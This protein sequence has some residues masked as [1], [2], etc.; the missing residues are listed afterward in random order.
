MVLACTLYAKTIEIPGVND[1]SIQDGLDSALTRDVVQ[2][3]AGTYYENLIWPDVSGISLVGNDSSNTVIDGGGNG[4]VITMNPSTATIDE[5]TVI[6]NFTIQNG[7]KSGNGAGIYLSNCSTLIENVVIKNN[8]S[9]Y[10]G[11][12]IYCTNNSSPELSKL[13]IFN[14]ESEDGAALYSN[15]STITINDAKIY[16]NYAYLYGG[17]ISA[18]ESD[19][20][21]NNSN[22][23]LNRSDLKGGGIFLYNSTL[24]LSDSKITKNIAKDDDSNEES[25]GGGIHS[26]FSTINIANVEINENSAGLYGGGISF[27]SSKF[28]NIENVLFAKNSSYKGGAIYSDNTKF[29][30][31]NS[32]LDN[33]TAS[34]TGDCIYIFGNNTSK[35]KNC[36][37]TGHKNSIELQTA[38]LDASNNYF[39]TIDGPFHENQNVSGI[40]DTVDVN[41]DILPF[42]KSPNLSAPPIAP[43][44]FSIIDESND[45]VTV[46]WDES[47]M[48][49]FEQY[50][51]FYSNEP[52][53]YQSS[54]DSVVYEL[55]G[56]TEFTLN[57]VTIGEAYY[58]A[59]ITIDRNSNRSWY[60]YEDSITIFDK[61][62]YVLDSL[63]D[64]SV[65]EDT[66]SLMIDLATVFSDSDDVDTDIYKS[67]VNISDSTLLSAKI[68]NNTLTLYLIKDQN[69]TAE[70]IINGFVNTKSANDTF[71]V[72]VLPVPD[73]PIGI[74]TLVVINEDEMLIFDESLMRFNDPDGDLFGGIIFTSLPEKGSLD[75]N[76]DSVRIN[77][78]YSE[79][80]DLFYQPEL[81]QYGEDYSSFSYYLFDD[82]DSTSS[83]AYT[84]TINV[85]PVDDPLNVAN[86][87]FDFS[88]DE[89]APD[90]TI[91]L[92]SLFF[93]DDGF[94]IMK[95][96]AEISD[97]TLIETIID[98]DSLTLKFLE[99]QNGFVDI[100]IAG[101][102]NDTSAID[103]FRVIINPINDNP[104]SRD[105]TIELDEDSVFDFVKND[106]YYEDFENDKSAG[107]IITTKP[108]KGILKYL[109]DEVITGTTYKYIQ[110]LQFI[111]DEDGTGNPYTSFDFKMVAIDK[112]ISDSAYTCTII[113]NG[114]D[115]PP[116]IK[117][118][119]QDFVISE[120]FPDTLI[121]LAEIFTD[122]DDSI[123]VKS[124]VSIS[125]TLL[126]IGEIFGDSLVLTFG[127][128]QFGSSE[129]VIEA[130]ANSKSVTDTML[131]TILPVNDKPFSKNDTIN[132]LEDE[133]YQFS[134]EDFYYKDIEN[135]SFTEI[136]IVR[137]VESGIFKL[138]NAEVDSIIP[139]VDI[140]YLTF[141]PA[142]NQIGSP[143][144]FFTFQVKDEDEFSDSLYT[145]II[146]VIGKNDP[147]SFVGTYPDTI[148][149]EDQLLSLDIIATDPE[150]DSLIFAI[151]SFFV[152]NESSWEFVEPANFDIFLDSNHFQWQPTFEHSNEY[153][154]KISVSD[155][156]YRDTTAFVITV[157]NINR[158]PT[159]TKF[160]TDTTINNDLEF[161][162][163]FSANDPDNDSLYYG[164]IENIDG[165]S[166]SDSGF[167]HWLV[168]EVPEESYFV[169]I[170]ATDVEDTIFASAR[171]NVIN[172]VAIE[173][174]EVLP[175]EFTL[176]QSYPNPFNPTTQIRY[177]LPKDT[178]VKLLIFNSTGKLV[179]KIVD[180]KQTAG[181]YDVQWNASDNSS[182]IYFYKIITP[183][184]INVKKCLLVK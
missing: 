61:P 23:F 138:G 129:I 171:I 41:V 29:E 125:D 54:L 31:N 94:D 56:D 162:Y 176:E 64:I 170:F 20:I 13:S 180:E 155:S 154:V 84:M 50:I 74:D 6:R 27:K 72:E 144:T 3:S 124:I 90:T 153:K 184:Y 9:T 111:P 121:S 159:F 24:N 65:P 52:I 46:G 36:N 113:V 28:S 123:L 8:I 135:N 33:N 7:Y 156:E 183:S 140:G 175:T 5:N 168:P 38:T 32:T 10:R 133:L 85:N 137:T 21:I 172:V 55:R 78:K 98:G 112:T 51:I 166:L 158:P 47:E 71:I 147:P 25:V 157:N 60:S 53:T 160:L 66:S 45:F 34:E 116:Q 73:Y 117:I 59:G 141:L 101:T 67:L 142:E 173:S 89:D 165:M 40:G 88:V 152:K 58:F 149:Y 17:G 163:N 118:Q 122:P 178:H 96:V 63:P 120:D 100:L 4:R 106:F 108:D 182:G 80:E 26:W 164:L 148:I 75:F 110:N 91:N 143:Y 99:N 37:I 62:P 81:N 127:E 134:I 139:V 2:V 132:I 14:N 167:F 145:T 35:I 43:Q 69:G 49:D 93:S 95:S 130:L 181:F 169:N 105:T 79:I 57:N 104:I 179:D 1:L 131:V 97:T 16:E 82:T 44:N 126:V 115:D 102:S 151:D 11:A 109:N 174:D 77:Q 48:G 136:R 103:T 161:T 42:L 119:L 92:E 18:Y 68:Q 128:N 15:R 22:I 87:L 76:D 30:V 12:A 114:F 83:R 86:P 146:N 19:V 177:T 150:N 70:V 39:G 107:I